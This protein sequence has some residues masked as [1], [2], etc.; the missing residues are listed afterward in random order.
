MSQVYQVQLESSVTH[1]VSASDEMTHKVELT[2][3]LG[4]EEMREILEKTL[5]EQ[6]WEK[7]DDGTYAKTGPSGEELVWD[8]E[9]NTVTAK[10]ED[11][12]DVTADISVRGRGG[13]RQG[14]RQNAERQVE[15]QR[16]RAEREAVKAE[17]EIEKRITEQLEQSEEKRMRELNGVVKRVYSEALKRKAETLGTVVSVDEHETAD[18][19]ELVIKIEN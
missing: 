14:A 5:Q 7:Q 8:L 11:E 19:Y 13:S 6:G 16:A 9:E 17:A 2:Q 10:I 12:R 4:Q 15:Q 1:T 18:D 3:I